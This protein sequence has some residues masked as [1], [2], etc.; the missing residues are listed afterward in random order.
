MI[1]YDDKTSN[2]ISAGTKLL[3]PSCHSSEDVTFK[4][5]YIVSS[6]LSCRGKITA[7]FDLIVFGDVNADEIDVKGRF[8]CMGHCKV[9]G[10]IVVQ[11]DMWCEDI[12]ATSITC[13]ARIVTQSI[14]A[15]NIFVDG[16]II[17]GKILTIEQIAQTNQNVICGETAYGAGKIIASR[18]LTG[19]PL[20]LDEGEDALQNPFTYSPKTQS[21]LAIK[22]S[23]Q[24]AKYVKNNDYSGYITALI[25]NSE[26]TV[27]KQL[28]KYLTVLKTVEIAISSSISEFRDATLLIWLLELSNSEYFKGWETVTEWTKAVLNHFQNIAEGKNTGK[29]AEKLLKGYTVFHTDYG[30]GIVIDISS[31]NGT[32]SLAKVKFD[33]HGLKMF[34]IPQTLKSFLVISESSPILSEDIKSSMTCDINNYEDWLTALEIINKNKVILGDNL[35]NS[36]FQLLM[37]IIGLKAKFVEDRFKEKGWC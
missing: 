34:P 26:E 20:D 8:I 28:N 21:E 5:S 7:L 33:K 36:I 30:K 2:A 31:R 17:V 13:H 27:E 1:A 37:N 10:S 35:H 24:S 15:D 11:N 29:S 6:D 4:A 18:I 12:Q 23:T 25:K 14:N 3:I 32:T 9:S 16:S 19:E 22:I